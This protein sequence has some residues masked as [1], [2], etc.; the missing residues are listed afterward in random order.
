M[1]EDVIQSLKE[2][3]SLLGAYQE[4]QNMDLVMTYNKGYWWCTSDKLLQKHEVSFLQTAK[5]KERC[6]S[7]LTKRKK[8]KDFSN[9]ISLLGW[10]KD[11]DWSGRLLEGYVSKN[12]YRVT[13]AALRA[14]FPKVV[15]GKYLLKKK[16]I[17]TA[18]YSHSLDVKNKILGI[19]AFA[20]IGTI[21]PHLSVSDRKY[22][23]SL[24][25]HK[26][27]IRITILARMAVDK[28]KIE[29]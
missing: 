20:P 7:M 19:L 26:D 22:L 21:Q 4:K 14:L 2:Y 3:V 23:Q 11:H 17:R 1:N 29:S 13:N 9:T 5:E 16:T 10:S 28:L 6:M 25:K 27:E 18:L 15:T 24:L 8:T 12:N